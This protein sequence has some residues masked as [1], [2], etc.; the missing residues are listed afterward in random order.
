MPTTTPPASHVDLLERPIFAHLATI[1]PDGS[2]QSSVMWFEWDGAHLGF[3]HTNTR[4]KF[5]NLARDGRVAISIA[6]PDNPYRFLEVRSE[7]DVIE[8]DPTGGYYNH[9]SERY[10]SGATVRTLRYG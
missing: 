10:G 7:V 4:Q 9:L 5:R 1:R 3:T 2:P 8:A 6:D